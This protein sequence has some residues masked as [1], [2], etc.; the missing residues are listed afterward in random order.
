ML[1]KGRA[2]MAMAK[3][4]PA[5]ADWTAIRSVIARANRLD[6]ENAEPLVMFYR[7]FVAQGVQPTKNAIDGLFYAVALAPQDLPICAWSWLAA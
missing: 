3:A 7:T 4:A 1:L 2:M 6:P 5:T